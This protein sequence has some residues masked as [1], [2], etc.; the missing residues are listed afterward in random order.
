MVFTPGLD[1][2]CHGAT[3]V[4]VS[5]ETLKHALSGGASATLAL[6]L[7]YPLDV[8]RTHIQLDRNKRQTPLTPL[9]VI[10]RIRQ[11]HGWTA[12]YDVSV[13]WCKLLVAATVVWFVELIIDPLPHHRGT[14]RVLVRTLSLNLCHSSCTFLYTTHSSWD[15]YGECFARR[16]THEYS[17]LSRRLGF[18]NNDQL[19]VHVCPLG[20]NRRLVHAK[21]IPTNPNIAIAAAAGVM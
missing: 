9:D 10:R 11:E 1:H 13:L 17:L 4:K 2:T 3:R 20:S 19:H 8:A 5:R 6:L 21:E 12:L 15:T 16:D 14:N 7:F 18:M